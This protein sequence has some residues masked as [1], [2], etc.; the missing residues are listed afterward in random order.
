MLLSTECIA[1]RIRR[2]KYVNLIRN[3]VGQVRLGGW[4][5]VTPT[6]RRR[7]QSWADPERSKPVFSCPV[8]SIEKV[9]EV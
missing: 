2:A 5:G 3:R 1:D 4:Q 6:T 9:F 7:L 8:E